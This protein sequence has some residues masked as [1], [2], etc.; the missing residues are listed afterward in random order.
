METRVIVDDDAGE[1][2]GE[3]VYHMLES[4][5]VEFACFCKID[6]S[7]IGISPSTLIKALVKQRNKVYEILSQTSFI[8]EMRNRFRLSNYECNSEF[9]V[10]DVEESSNR[11]FLLFKKKYLHSPP[12]QLLELTPILNQ[13]LLDFLVMKLEQ[14]LCC[15]VL[16]DQ[17]HWVCYHYTEESNIKPL[18]E[19]L[20][21][22]VNFLIDR[23]RTIKAQ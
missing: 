15:H 13:L 11:K 8:L 20:L 21:N 12:T 9:N 5:L 18:Q 1:P 10:S 16:F 14:L 3:D 19:E 2:Q 4:C 7:V 17:E 23:V 22:A 6:A